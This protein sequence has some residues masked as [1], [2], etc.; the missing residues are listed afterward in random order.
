MPLYNITIDNTNDAIQYLPTN[1]G[2]DDLSGDSDYYEGTYT[3]CLG[4]DPKAEF[5]FTR[6]FATHFDFLFQSDCPNKGVAAYVL[7]PRYPGEYNIE[8]SLDGEP[9]ASVNVTSPT[10]DLRSTE[11]IWSAINL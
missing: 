8:F 5:M 11:V 10:G 7:M 3:R 2:W 1:C 6:E 4:R 9:S